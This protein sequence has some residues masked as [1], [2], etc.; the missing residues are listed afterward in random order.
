MVLSFP[1][2]LGVSC[3]GG[4]AYSTGIIQKWSNCKEEL[5]KD[6]VISETYH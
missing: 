2:T 4:V 5:T 1:K 3:E 6:R